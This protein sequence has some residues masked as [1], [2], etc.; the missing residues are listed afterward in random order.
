VENTKLANTVCAQDIEL[1]FG[2]AYCFLIIEVGNRVCI[3]GREILSDGACE[4]G[5]VISKIVLS[6]LLFLSCRKGYKEISSER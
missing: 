4:T 3:E 2:N 6:S 5:K 1:L